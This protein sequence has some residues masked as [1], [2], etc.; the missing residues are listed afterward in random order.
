MKVV[1][2]N[3]RVSRKCNVLLLVKLKDTPGV[4]D[5]D[6]MLGENGIYSRVWQDDLYGAFRK[7]GYW[8][9]DQLNVG[10]ERG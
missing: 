2:Y 4:V 5:G 1:C 3:L 10:C 8:N 9:C 6:R 7:I